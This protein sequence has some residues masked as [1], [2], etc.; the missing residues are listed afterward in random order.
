MNCDL[1]VL[2]AELEY[3]DDEDDPIPQADGLTGVYNSDDDVEITIHCYN[4]S[5][6]RK[7]VTLY[8]LFERSEER[9]V[10]Y[11]GGGLSSGALYVSS[12]SDSL[13]ESDSVL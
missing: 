9:R 6:D 2:Y 7:V 10:H 5:K 1:D 13:S 12:S 3:N 4:L 11:V 8:N